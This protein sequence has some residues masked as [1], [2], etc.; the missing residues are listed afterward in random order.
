MYVEYYNKKHNST[1]ALDLPN[2]FLIVTVE[3][4]KTEING[5]QCYVSDD[6]GYNIVTMEL[7]NSSKE[8]PQPE[9]ES[10]AISTLKAELENAKKEL[11]KARERNTNLTNNLSGLFNE[12]QIAFLSKKAS[13]ARGIMWFFIVRVQS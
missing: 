3:A 11:K 6:N 2:I 5:S 7:D 4:P 8:T 10:E 13:G 9:V 12:D 1:I